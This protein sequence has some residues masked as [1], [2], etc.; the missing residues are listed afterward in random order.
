MAVKSVSEHHPCS[1]GVG[2]LATQIHS[3]IDYVASLSSVPGPMRRTENTG[4]HAPA[5]KQVGYREAEGITADGDRSYE[6]NEQ[7]VAGGDIMK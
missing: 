3:L 7:R 2:S 5:R 1:A 4:F 6:D